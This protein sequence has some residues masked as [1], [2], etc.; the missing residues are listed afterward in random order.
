MTIVINEKIYTEKQSDARKRN[1]VLI[2]K[3]RGASNWFGVEV[4]KIID[5]TEKAIRVSCPYY[6][7][8][9]GYCVNLEVWHGYQI[10][11]PKSSIKEV[12]R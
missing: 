11:L 7:D 4:D 1:M 5:E 8:D 12:R 2:A 9:G 10:W 3:R 6:Y